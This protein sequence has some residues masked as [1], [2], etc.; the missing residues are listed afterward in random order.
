MG[1]QNSLPDVTDPIVA[2]M[3]ELDTAF[4]AEFGD[5]PRTRTSF[6]T[7]SVTTVSGACAVRNP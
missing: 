1:D 7:E 2:Q 6:S 4:L 3:R 5:T